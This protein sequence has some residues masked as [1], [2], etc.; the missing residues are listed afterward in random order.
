MNTFDRQN[1]DRDFSW[2]QSGILVDSQYPRPG[3]P[4][5]YVEIRGSVEEIQ[6]FLALCVDHRLKF[7][8][9]LRPALSQNR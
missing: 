3:R 1:T 8:I 4:H 7:V 9:H 5:L 6:T 2:A